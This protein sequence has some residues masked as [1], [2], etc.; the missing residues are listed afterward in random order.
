MDRE[1]SA[2]GSPARSVKDPRSPASSQAGWDDRSWPRGAPVHCDGRVARLATTPDRYGQV[3]LEWADGSKTAFVRVTALRRAAEVDWERARQE[4]AERR[5]QRSLE[6]SAR[7]LELRSGG[8][9]PPR[10]A[11]GPMA[12][13]SERDLKIAFE[14]LDE[15]REGALDRGQARSWLRCAGWC[16]PDEELDEMLAG[17]GVSR[18]RGVAHPPRT[19]WGLKNLVEVLNQNRHRENSSV[20][21]LQ[22]ALRRLAHQRGKIPR[23]RLVEFTTQEHD[24]TKANLD[25]VL[26]SLGLASANVL[27]CDSLA[28]RVMERVCNP[29]SVLDF[30]SFGH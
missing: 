29:P 22:A 23:E 11:G 3:R 27:D 9:P 18:G 10:G 8:A 16:V 30:N 7:A 26:A 2:T 13:T 15:R 20:E 19:K 5:E 28:V 25:E 21:A 17:V 12:L 1:H 4:E 6:Q 24:L 14:M